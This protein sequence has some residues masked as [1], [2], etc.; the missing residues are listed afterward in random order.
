[1][2]K[3]KR[4]PVACFR[5]ISKPVT[6]QTWSV[7][8][9]SVAFSIYQYVLLSCTWNDAASPPWYVSSMGPTFVTTTLTSL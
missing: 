5:F 6:C 1:M 8:R 9:P 3:I 4:K 2:V 7:R